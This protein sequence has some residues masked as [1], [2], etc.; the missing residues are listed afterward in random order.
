LSPVTWK[1]ICITFLV[2]VAFC[3]ASFELY[4]FILADIYANSARQKMTLKQNDAGD[5]LIRRCLLQHESDP[6]YQYL[7][8]QLLYAQA[9]E[10]QD[11]ATAQDLLQLAKARLQ[12]S[13]Q[14]NPREG[15]VW[16]DMAQT[17]WWLGGFEGFQEELGQVEAHFLQAVAIDPNNGKFLYALVNYYLSSKRPDDWSTYLKRL[18]LVYPNAYYT[19]KEHPQ[20]SQTAREQFK[21]GLQ[22]GLANTL[23]AQQANSALGFMAA[24][25]K[26]WQNATVYTQEFIRRLG[27]AASPQPYL[28]L[29]RYFLQLAEYDQAKTAFLQGLKLSSKRE[30]LLQD[31]LLPCLEAGTFSLYVALCQDTASFDVGVRNNLSFI[32]GKAS[33]AFDSLDTAKAYLR[34]SLQVQERAEAHRYLAEIAVR[35]KDWDTMELESQ[36]ATVLEPG[37]SYYYYLLARSLEAQNKYD[38]AL[39]AIS[40]AIHYAQPPQESYF[41]MQGALYQLKKK[42]IR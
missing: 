14:L 25:E 39:E 35:R 26:D 31:L 42:Q 33:F 24:E 15:N 8:A 22:M 6:E 3:Y 34:E 1:K 30:Q 41:E 40:Q 21:A 29:G 28:D 4:H 2:I 5:S 37:N 23:T 9:K 32:L 13:L 27:P 17:C 38:S 12:Q 10:T 18:A 7:Y 16:L 11:L 20:W 19:L 36:R